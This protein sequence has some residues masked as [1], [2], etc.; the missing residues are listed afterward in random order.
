[1]YQGIGLI[2]GKV[3]FD[4]EDNTTVIIEGEEFR[5]TCFRFAK[6]RLRKYL[7]EN[8]DISI[9][10]RVYPRLNIATKEIR[11]HAYSC[12]TEKPKQTQVNQFLLAEV[13]QCIPQL[14]DDPVISVYRNQL[15][16][17]EA[18]ARVR[19]NHV[20]IKGFEEEP[21]IFD[22]EHAQD[23]KPPKFYEL[24]AQFKP[25]QKEFQFLLLLDSADRPPRRVK[26][27]KVKSKKKRKKN[28]ASP[29]NLELNY[30][31][32]NFSTLQKTA[33][34]LRE[35]G[36]MEG[37]VS[38]KGVTKEFLTTKIQ[39]TLSTNPEAAKVLNSGS[40]FSS[41]E[42]VSVS[43]EAANSSSTSTAVSEV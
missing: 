28:L 41:V 42:T 9:Y 37:K 29:E 27:R 6:E 8:P 21:F 4:E 7:A 26:K 35:S 13:W 34:K 16:P 14:P 25:K 20:P 30:S 24:I 40:I 3:V 17:K 43:S 11:F 5:L 12:Y 2:C 1:M 32:M 31:S 38:G 18:R 19:Y 10:L 23:N 15:R 22:P 39:D 33:L 36:F